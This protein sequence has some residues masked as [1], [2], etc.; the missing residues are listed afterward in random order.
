MLTTQHSPSR[1]LRN[2]G[3]IIPHKDHELNYLNLFTSSPGFLAHISQVILPFEEWTH[4]FI[5]SLFF[6]FI[7]KSLRKLQA[8]NSPLEMKKTLYTQLTIFSTLK[9]CVFNNPISENGYGEEI[10]TI[11]WLLILASM[12]KTDS[13]FTKQVSSSFWMHNYAGYSDEAMWM[14]IKA[15]EREKSDGFKVR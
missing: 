15:V 6:A 10:M 9:N 14:R 11:S 12:A 5:F 8:I 7:S 2:E 13:L 1:V 3:K 4:F